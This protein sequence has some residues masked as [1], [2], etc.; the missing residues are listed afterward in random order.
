VI[1]PTKHTAANEALIGAGAL[2]LQQTSKPIL[3]SNL[4]E[5]VKANPAVQ[6]YERFILTLD[7]LHI[8]GVIDIEDN[9]IVRVEG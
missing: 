8:I 1:L 6:T 9:M 4:W 2:I 3:L 5:A 7:M